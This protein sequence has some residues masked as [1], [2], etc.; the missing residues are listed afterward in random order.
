MP[1]PGVTIVLKGTA[2]GTSS[3][4]DGNY[5]ITVPDDA[6]TL[7]F[8]FIGFITKEVAINNQSVINVMLSEDVAQLDEVVVIGYGT[9]SKRDLIGSVTQLTSEDIK[10]LPVTSVD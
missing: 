1:L 6:K 7:V 3:D 4:F 5:T 8:S 9:S 10:D 2:I